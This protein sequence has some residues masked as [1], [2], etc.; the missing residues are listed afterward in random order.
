MGLTGTT[1]NG[2]VE[3]EIEVMITVVDTTA[4]MTMIEGMTADMIVVTM[5]RGMSAITAVIVIVIVTIEATE[6]ACLQ[7]RGLPVI[8][9]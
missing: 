7:R 8:Q 4:G 5:I 6:C 2:T 3:I 1:E 9:A